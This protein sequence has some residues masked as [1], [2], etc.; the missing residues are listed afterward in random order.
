MGISDLV[1]HLRPQNP[2]LPRYRCECGF[3]CYS[4]GQESYHRDKACL[5]TRSMLNVMSARSRLGHDDHT[6]LETNGLI[7]LERLNP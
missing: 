5:A 2:P 6:G 3:P 4:Q 7:L 1:A